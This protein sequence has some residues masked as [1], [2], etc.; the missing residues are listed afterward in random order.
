[1]YCM[2]MYGG[3]CQPHWNHLFF[4]KGGSRDQ[5]AIRNSWIQ[6]ERMR[7]ELGWGTGSPNRRSGIVLLQL[8]TNY[9]R[10]PTWPGSVALQS[11]PLNFFGIILS[12]WVPQNDLV[13]RS[14]WEPHL[15]QFQYLDDLFMGDGPVLDFRTIS[16]GLIRGL[17]TSYV[18]SFLLMAS[19]LLVW[20][21]HVPPQPNGFVCFWTFLMSIGYG[22]IPIDTFLVG[23]TSIYQIFF[24]VH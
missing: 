14:F 16:T 23:W 22:S 9:I 18:W 10:Y 3:Q 1:M 24:G 7:V 8:G 17:A 13:F 12:I 4:C 11:R 21:S 5:G 2:E 19:I 15:S 20:P 6:S